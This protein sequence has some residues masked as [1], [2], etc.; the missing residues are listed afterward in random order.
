[1]KERLTALAVQLGVAGRITFM[2]RVSHEEK[3]ACYRAAH[4][5]VLPATHRSEA[6]GLVQVEALACGLPVICT[7]IDSGVPVVNRDGVTGF[8]VEP[9]DPDGLA[10]AL[11]R[12]LG[13]R[14]LHAAFARAARQRATEVYSRDV[15][16]RDVHALYDDLLAGPR[17]MPAPVPSA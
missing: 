7:N 5:L 10:A 14:T 15:M 8:V 4:C 3:V 6:F 17:G 16:L 12:L 1:M 13:D 9:S 11:E 2:G